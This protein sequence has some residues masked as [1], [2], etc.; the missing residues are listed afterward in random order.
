[1]EDHKGEK[2]IRKYKCFIILSILGL[3]ALFSLYISSSIMITV[4]MDLE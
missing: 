1:M 4:C 3:L 2:E